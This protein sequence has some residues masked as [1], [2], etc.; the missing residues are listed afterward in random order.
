MGKK[1]I[2]IVI[3]A[4]CLFFA[5]LAG[6][7]IVNFRMHVNSDSPGAAT[8][9]Q[10][11]GNG[12]QL[13]LPQLGP[14]G[15]PIDGPGAQN[16]GPGQAGGEPTTARPYI[17]M[18]LPSAPTVAVTA[19][20]QYSVPLDIPVETRGE[21]YSNRGIPEGVAQIFAV[22]GRLL[23]SYA[24]RWEG[25]EQTRKTVDYYTMFEYHPDT[26]GCTAVSDEVGYI[27]RIGDRFLYDKSGVVPGDAD[28]WAVPYYLN[29]AAWNN[30][31]EITGA[32]ARQLIGAPRTAMING[33]VQA[34][35]TAYTGGAITVTLP[36]TGEVFAVTLDT[37]NAFGVKGVLSG[38]MV[39]IRGVANGRVYLSASCVPEEGVYL[40]ELLCANLDGSGLTPL[41]YDG[42]PIWA[43][44]YG[45][46]DDGCIYGVLPAGKGTSLLRVDTLTNEV[47]ALAT[48]KESVWHFV[49][50]DDYALYEIPSRDMNQANTLGC[51]KIAK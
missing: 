38:L 33:R 17:P 21:D 35:T 49:A 47:K 40:R 31:I 7:L 5:V 1:Q 9:A 26:G 19:G 20:P 12:A 45:S 44:P 48:V 30:E 13:T 8:G 42:N 11:G 4:A 43:D 36:E 2:L 34:Y 23:F 27:T 18:E 16:T 3:A 14:D 15:K 32:Q 6:V 39:D 37:K 29:T 41:R 50:T 22:D 28:F 24:T 51:V 46:M 10:T 25:D